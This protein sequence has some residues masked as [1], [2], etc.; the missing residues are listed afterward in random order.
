MGAKAQQREPDNVLANTAIGLG[1]RYRAKSP[2]RAPLPWERAESDGPC[3]VPAQARGSRSVTAISIN[4]HGQPGGKYH[5]DN[6]RTGH[7]H[8]GLVQSRPSALFDDLAKD[9]AFG[10]GRPA[11]KESV[12]SMAQAPVIKSIGPRE[13]SVALTGAN[14]TDE[15]WNVNVYSNCRGK[16]RRLGRLDRS[17]QPSE[18]PARPRAFTFS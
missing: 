2:F 1:H 13:F 12:C 5:Q 6:G 16:G 4:G 8:G 15:T 9:T 14:A 18:C 7:H 3:L 17:R 10:R 11:R